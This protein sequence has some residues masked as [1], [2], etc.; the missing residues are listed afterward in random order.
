MEHVAPAQLQALRAGGF[1]SLRQWHP[2]ASID[3]S[4]VT[5]AQLDHVFYPYVTGFMAGPLGLIFHFVLNEPVRHDPGPW[6]PDWPSIPRSLASFGAEGINHW[7]VLGGNPQAAAQATH[8][9]YLFAQAPALADRLDLEDWWVERAN[10]LEYELLDPTAFVDAATDCIDFRDVFEH[11]LTVDRVRRSSLAA[12]TFP[13]PSATKGNV[14]AIADLYET[15]CRVHRPLRPAGLP[16]LPAN[17]AQNWFKQLFHPTWAPALIDHCFATMPP[18]IRAQ[19]VQARDAAYAQLTNSVLNGVFMPGARQ[20]G[21][22]VSVAGRGGAPPAVEAD[23]VF[24][25]NVMRALRNTHHGYLT[26]QDPHAEAVSRYLAI[27]NGN[28]TDDIS[29]LPAI[30][31]L[32]CLG[33]PGAFC[34]ITTQPV[35]QRAV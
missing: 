20:A 24:V 30:W 9:R 4:R 25:A 17:Q 28:V 13:Y 7:A 6:P 19:L 22:G 12:N 18:G 31:W 14:F 8:H 33:N 35:G 21:G 23:D 27:T 34:G 3:A 5:L 11:A 2:L 16:A 32:A 15:L 1:E 10:A 26:S 29:L